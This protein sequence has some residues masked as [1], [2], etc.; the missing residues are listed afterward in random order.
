MKIDDLL[1]PLRAELEHLNDTKAKASKL[2]T[3]L[4]NGEF[5]YRLKASLAPEVFEEI[6]LARLDLLKGLYHDRL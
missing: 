2:L 3:L 4:D 6:R 5:F 1:E